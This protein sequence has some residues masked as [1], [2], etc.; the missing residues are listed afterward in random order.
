MHSRHGEFARAASITREARFETL[1]RLGQGGMGLVDEVRDHLLDR[2]VARKRLLRGLA[3]RPEALE[4]FVREIR[5]TARLQHP[6]IVAV[7]DARLDDGEGPSL[8]MPRLDGRPLTEVI[9]EA[10]AREPEALGAEALADLVEVVV[11]A[12]EAVSYAH[13]E[14]VLHR[15]L[16]PANIMVGHYGEVFVLDWGIALERRPG[17]EAPCAGNPDETGLVGTPAYMAPETLE[18][19]DDLLDA[20]SDVYALGAMLAEILLGR[21]PRDDHPGRSDTELMREVS[22]GRS[23]AQDIPT[24]PGRPPQLVDIIKKA[25]APRRED[26]HASVNELRADL[27]RFL[28]G[29]GALPRVWIAE[30]EAVVREGEA[31]DCAYI[32]LE[33]RCRVVRAGGGETRVRRELEPGDVFGETALLAPGP[34]T[35]TVVAMTDAVLLR[36]TEEVLLREVSALKPWLATL[37]RSLAARARELEDER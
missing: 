6:G 15:D 2:L 23:L 14:G 10:H 7:H 22:E 17:D 34:R 21:P 25:T 28:R 29:G 5:V 31:G 13:D 8:F 1:G 19:R 12:S 24:G 27:R 9:G 16:K 36:V 20:R 11:R 26:R 32:L 4:R 18:G 30:G 37:V 33:G 35:A 3:E